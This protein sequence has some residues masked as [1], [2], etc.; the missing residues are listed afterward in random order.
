MRVKREDIRWALVEDGAFFNDDEGVILYET[1]KEARMYR[2]SWARF[3]RGHS[4]DKRPP[5]VVKVRVLVE[6]IKCDGKPQETP[7]E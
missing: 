6:V 5:S 7:D 2:N 1:R 3:L 4:I